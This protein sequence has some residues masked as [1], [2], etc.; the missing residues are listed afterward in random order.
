MII[1]WCSK[2]IQ[3][4]N[5][6]LKKVLSILDVSRSSYY[7]H[8]S[9]RGK[10]LKRKTLRHP[11]QVLPEERAAVIRYAREHP[12]IRHRALAYAMIDDNA[13]CLSP[14]TVYRI[15]REEDLVCRWKPNKNRAK[16]IRYKGS[17]PDE[18]WQSDIRY[19]KIGK[20]TYYLI[21]FIDEYS[22]FNTHHELMRSMDGNSVALAAGK[23]LSQLPPNRKPLIQTDNGSGYISHEF[24]LVLSD[25]GVGHHRIKP[26]CPEENGIV[27]R[28]NRTLG[29][30]ID[31]MELTDFQLAKEKIAEIVH[32]YNHERLHSGID[33]LPPYEMYRGD[34]AKR[35][36]ERRR[37]VEEARLRRREENLKRNQRTLPLHSTEMVISKN[38]LHES[39]K[40]KACL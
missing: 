12:D 18:K 17:K 19:V 5:W 27:E 32:W 29:D 28:S 7:R 9:N 16:R 24:K 39:G 22:R 33:F 37:K 30:K 1:G 15:L 23:A 36:A 14:S 10:P 34:P 35:L 31:E 26:H 4:S 11:H 38:M 3:Q 8:L 20:R 6:P 25:Q 13:A 21:N 40:A 2:T